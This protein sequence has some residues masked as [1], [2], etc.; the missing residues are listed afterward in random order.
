MNNRIKKLRVE[1]KLSQQK[2]ADEIGITRQA[3]SL[4]EKGD[5]KPKLETWVKLANYFDV[6][7][8]YLQGLSSYKNFS[9]EARLEDLIE[10][11]PI[12]LKIFGGEEKLRQELNSS[13][14]DLLLPID[15]EEL[16]NMNYERDV[17]KLV[18]LKKSMDLFSFVDDPIR[19]YAK[20]NFDKLLSDSENGDFA[21]FLLSAYSELLISLSVYLTKNEIDKSQND[22]LI[23]NLKTALYEF[24]FKKT[25]NKFSD[26]WN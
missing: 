23:D 4:F 2:L 25:G 24:Y 1:K 15:A 8:S 3:I 21:L 20:K 16:S 6:S 10:N 11:D 12:T 7:I 17:K 22:V 19:A 14:G 26:Y 5:R 18:L 13:N 9:P